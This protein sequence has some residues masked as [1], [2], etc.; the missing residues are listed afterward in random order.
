LTDK[1]VNIKFKENNFIYKKD[2]NFGEINNKI[3]DNYEVADE[4]HR[5]YSESTKTMNFY[6]P[7]ELIDTNSKLPV[8]N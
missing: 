4:F 8:K 2:T 7:T 6:L 1:K 5:T 3:I